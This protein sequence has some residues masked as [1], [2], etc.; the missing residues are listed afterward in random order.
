[1]PSSPHISTNPVIPST[2]VEGV[3][4]YD[5]HGRK[6]GRIDHLL[7]DK[8]SGFV[9]GVVLNVTGFFGIGHS[10]RQLAWSSLRYSTRLHGYEV[11]TVAAPQDKVA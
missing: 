1:M 7:I 10:H 4:V 11:V 8:V 3:P 6:L 9:V 5:Q 2:D